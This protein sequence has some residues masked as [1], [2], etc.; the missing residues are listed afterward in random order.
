MPPQQSLCKAAGEAWRKL[1][2]EQR[3]PYEDLSY[4]G[5]AA[6]A[7]WAASQQPAHRPRSGARK[8]RARRPQA[9]RRH[10]AEES[11][12][13]HPPAEGQLQDGDLGAWGCLQA[14]EQLQRLQDQVQV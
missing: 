4:A 3:Q 13:P 10:L 9:E 11:G 7:A 5:K 14:A 8:R 2:V 1:T 12:A 6:W